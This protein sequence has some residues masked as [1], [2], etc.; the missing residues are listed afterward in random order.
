M[1][2]NTNSGSKLKW[3]LIK[4]SSRMRQSE[5]IDFEI[6]RLIRMCKSIAFVLSIPAIL[7]VC[8]S[9]LI[10][11]TPVLQDGF[12][13]FNPGLMA[14]SISFKPNLPSSHTLISI[15][16]RVKRLD[17]DDQKFTSLEPYLLVNTTRNKFTLFNRGK[18]VRDGIC[19]TGSYILLDAGDEKKWKFETP[20]GLFHVHG[21]TESPI[22]KKPDWAFIEEG[23]PVPPSYSYLRYE[24]GVLGDYALSIG[25]LKLFI[26]L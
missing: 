22:W 2:N 12:V 25:T 26:I 7:I 13:R 18:I 21:K 8:Y 15:E 6:A 4:L 3:L 9:L 16:N 1:E 23:L 10:F 24:R 5:D 20:K 19:S 11:L 17:R 14:D